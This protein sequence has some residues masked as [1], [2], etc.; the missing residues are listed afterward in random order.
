LSSDDNNLIRS[1][2]LNNQHFLKNLVHSTEIVN[3]DVCMADDMNQL[4]E[5]LNNNITMTTQTSRSAS[6]SNRMASPALSTSS[7]SSGRASTL[8]NHE[9]IQLPVDLEREILIKTGFDQLGKRK[10][11]EILFEF[12]LFRFSC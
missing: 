6:P 1:S 11:N 12:F 2:S 10:P 4:D 3:Q 5:L 9:I 7:Q 8:L